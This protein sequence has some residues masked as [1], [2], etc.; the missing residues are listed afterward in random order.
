[1]SALSRQAR[2]ER[3]L[4]KGERCFLDLL[5]GVALSPAPAGSRGFDAGKKLK[6]RKRHVMAIVMGM[7]TAVVVQSTGI[8]DRDGGW[9]V[10]NTVPTDQSGIERVIVD[11]NDTGGFEKWVGN[12]RGWIVEIVN[13]DPEH[14]GD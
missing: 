7:L 5:P 11:S 2:V 9:L 1:M 6:G 10:V 8:Q 4:K 12:Q 13:K 3:A 14:K